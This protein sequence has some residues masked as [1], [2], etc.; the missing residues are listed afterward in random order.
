VL[1]ECPSTHA[2]KCASNAASPPRHLT[3]IER[4][5]PWREDYGPQWS[6]FPIARLRYTAANK[7]WTLYWR[8]H[9]LRF[10]LYGHP[11]VSSEKTTITVG[12]SP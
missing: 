1:H 7:I 4:R 8:D 2:T 5:A 3:I 11:V 12:R 6:S 10:H 9:N